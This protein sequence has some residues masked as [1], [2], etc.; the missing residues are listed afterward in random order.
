MFVFLLLISLLAAIKDVTSHRIPNIYVCL[1]Y[2]VGAV[3]CIYKYGIWETLVFV[4]Y[5]FLVIAILFPFY[6]NKLIGAGDVKL[7]ALLPYYCRLTKI[8][9]S[10]LFILCIGMVVY[11]VNIIL[12]RI[13][14]KAES[15]LKHVR[16]D[17]TDGE[18]LATVSPLPN[19]MS[20]AIPMALPFFIGLLIEAVYFGFT[21]QE[22]FI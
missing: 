12:I 4:K 14:S 19:T 1:G 21:N 16:P 15:R 11:V 20:K 13:C 7:Y 10:Y 3:M 17:S 2:V 5:S 9:S 6:L 8:L 18:F 22:F